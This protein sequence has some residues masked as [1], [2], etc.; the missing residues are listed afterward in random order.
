[1]HDYTDKDGDT[2]KL[3]RECDAGIK[4]GISS[5]DDVIEDVKSHQFRTLLTECKAQHEKLAGEI[6]NLLDDHNDDGKNPNPMAKSMSWVKTNMKMM[7][8]PCDSTIADLMTDGCNMGVKSLNKYLNQYKSADS[9]SKNIT[10][11]LVQIESK[12]TD[13][14]S[15]YL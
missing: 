13:D 3:L 10:K 12:L 4:M 9:Q 6:L 7:A 15:P 2:V 1:M 11:R 5:I 14:I 8:N